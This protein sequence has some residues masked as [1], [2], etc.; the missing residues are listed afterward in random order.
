MFTKY[1]NA[2][3]TVGIV[4]IA[5][6]LLASAAPDWNRYQHA[7][8]ADSYPDT[9][10]AT[11][12]IAGISDRKF[13]VESISYNTIDNEASETITVTD[14]SATPAWEMEL[15]VNGLADEGYYNFGRGIACATGS[16]VIIEFSGT[17]TEVGLN[18]TGHYE[19]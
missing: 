14:A 12:V 16:A 1:K 18:V 5:V 7:S 2:L 11:E 15:S 10:V 9:T 4:A 17:S 3:A 6:A 19:P 13:W 8:V